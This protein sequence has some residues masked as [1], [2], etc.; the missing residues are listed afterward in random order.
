MV[1]HA[2]ILIVEGQLPETSPVGLECLTC[3][4]LIGR[5]HSVVRTKLDDNP[6]II[7]KVFNK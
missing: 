1:A 7:C 5:V 6:L 2:A 4:P 3:K